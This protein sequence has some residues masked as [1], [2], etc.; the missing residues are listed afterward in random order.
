MLLLIKRI[1]EFRIKHTLEKQEVVA[2][3]GSRSAQEWTETWAH[4]DHLSLS[5]SLESRGQ[6][7]CEC[8][9]RRWDEQGRFLLAVRKD[10]L[11]DLWFKGKAQLWL[12]RI[13]AFY[14][15][16]W[17]TEDYKP[18]PQPKILGLSS[19]LRFCEGRCKQIQASQRQT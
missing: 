12:E 10:E 9:C 6:N 3:L 4:R 18:K 19:S 15:I 8:H 13:G 17:N 1:V 11:E 16:S 14:S 2:D 5:S 7:G